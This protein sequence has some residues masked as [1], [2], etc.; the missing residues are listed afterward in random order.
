MKA[1]MLDPEHRAIEPIDITDHADIAR[2]IGYDTIE[3]DAV[4]SADDRLF[5]DEECF[6]R[7]A[8]VVSRSAA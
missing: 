6:L 4:G 2:L 3:S 8:K 1:L 7:G 5:F